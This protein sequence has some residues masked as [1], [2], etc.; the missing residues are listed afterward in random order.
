MKIVNYFFIF[1]LILSCQAP[2]NVEAL[3]SAP[4]DS[5]VLESVEKDLFIQPW[6]EYKKFEFVYTDN[7]LELRLPAANMN[8]LN[9][10]YKSSAMKS[11][12]SYDTKDESYLS[13][14]HHGLLKWSNLTSLSKL[15]ELKFTCK[16][17]QDTTGFTSSVD[18]VLF[19]NE[20]MAVVYV[21]MRPKKE[22]E[23]VSS[24]TGGVH[25]GI[26]YIVRFNKADGLYSY[27]D[28]TGLIKYAMKYGSDPYF[29]KVHND[30]IRPYLEV[31][32]DAGGT[33]IG[34]EGVTVYDL[35][36]LSEIIYSNIFL[37]MEVKIFW[38]PL[39]RDS[40]YWIC[41]R[42]NIDTSNVKSEVRLES[43]IDNSYQF[44]DQLDTLIVNRNVE[45]RFATWA[46]Q[47]EPNLT[48]YGDTISG[49]QFRNFYYSK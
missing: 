39:E 42:L 1:L 35:N 13:L 30:R 14:H 48:S 40:A 44:N 47:E 20:N 11:F 18:S 23:N 8:K 34:R 3:E 33:G 24:W 10:Q 19:E 28:N 37:T 49:L 45:L 6:E 26:E 43:W 9:A 7:S 2:G 16:F 46:E 25:P 31:H 27:T 36:D 12:I 17:Y 15:D 29:M 22:D 5:I 21:K 32:T 41:D 38:L 4:L